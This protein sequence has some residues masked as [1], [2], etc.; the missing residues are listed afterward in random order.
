MAYA[1]L[2]DIDS[3]QPKTK[4]DNPLFKE[5]AV[6]LEKHGAL[7]RFGI[8]LL[9]THFPVGENEMLLET[10]DRDARE[11]RVCPIALAE[12]EGL[13]MIETSWRL[14]PDGEAVMGCFCARDP[15]DG[16]HTGQHLPSRLG[17]QERQMQQVV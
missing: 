6:V 17:A 16:Q 8:T 5:L 4:A 11:Q 7:D 1:G 3:V 2:P 10:T 12:V 13:D 9:H 14:R 15:R